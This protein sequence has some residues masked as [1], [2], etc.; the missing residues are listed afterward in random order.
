MTAI[1]SHDEMVALF[2]QQLELCKLTTV[3][4]VAVLHEGS[5]LA[6]Y[7]DAFL[8]A[9]NMIGANAVDV[10]LRP[11]LET[12]LEERFTNFGTNPLNENPDA[13]QNCKDADI[14][15][16]LMVASFSAAETEIK[17]ADS[18][19]LLVCEEFDTL[20]RLLPT[21][22]LKARTE[23]SLARLQAARDFRFT[24]DAGT[25]ISYTF[26]PN[27]TPLSEYGYT[28]EPGRWDH[29]P[30]GLAAHCPEDGTTEG[31]VVMDEGD[32]IYPCMEF[33]RQPIEFVVEKGYVTE[34]KGR[35][36]AD[37]LRKFMDDYDDPRAYA[38]SHIGWG[39]N[40]K[41]DW[42]L[43]GIGMDGRAYDGVVLFS[44]GPNLEFGG[45]NDTKCHMDLPMRNCTAYLDG[46]KIIDN[47][48]LLP[49]DLK[50]PEH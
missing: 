14:V 24:N 35:E 30:G 28:D 4:T 10:H 48:V 20:N 6:E 33:V 46:G 45:T 27:Y 25:D 18:R 8:D 47:G 29:W 32:I 13:L 43:K 36:H 11:E 15:V 39:T 3:E 2:K 49:D 7:A 40:E 1:P 12:S 9:A 42:V 19:I 5:C 37:A 44:L 31:R 34:I 17:D 26:G 50:T 16:D 23:A 41:C 22:E 21:P 38:V